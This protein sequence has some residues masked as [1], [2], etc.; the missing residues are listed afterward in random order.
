MPW[1]RIRAAGR[2]RARRN[3]SPLILSTEV[4][5]GPT[6]CW[7]CVDVV[8]V[9]AS[10]SARRWPA[11]MLSS[12][13]PACALCTPGTTSQCMAVSAG[14]RWRVRGTLLLMSR[15]KQ[16]RR[17]SR[18]H[19]WWPGKARRRLC[20]SQSGCKRFPL[21]CTFDLCAQ[22]SQSKTSTKRREGK[23]LASFGKNLFVEL[24]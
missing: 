18:R 14:G 20:S 9:E 16:A 21:R 22:S 23:A 1:T 8:D 7:P 4:A 5:A 2:A 12:L 6:A 17:R 10:I 19:H 15:G 11:W 13:R 24:L 3:A